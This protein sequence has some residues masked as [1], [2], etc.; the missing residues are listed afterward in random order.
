MP[1]WKKQTLKMRDDHT[2]YSEPG[3]KVFVADRGAV[4]FDFPEEWV[5]VPGTDC[6]QFHDKAPPD[7]DCCLGFSYQRLPPIDWSG[8]RLAALLEQACKGDTRPIT[9]WGEM[10]EQQRGNLEIAWLEMRFVDPGE[11]REARS[12]MCLARQGQIQALLTFDFWET[13]L[14]RCHR[15]WE[16]VLKTLELDEVIEDPT[17]GRIVH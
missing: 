17:K 15:A 2:W 5:V 9:E 6:I 14:E 4:R 8:L 1:K 12:R 3:C 11:Q 10:S 7:D 13:D 16:I